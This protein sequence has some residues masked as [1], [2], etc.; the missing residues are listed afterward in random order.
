[1]P[2]EFDKTPNS[3]EKLKKR[4]VRVRMLMTK[5]EY[6]VGKVYEVTQ[7]LA[8]VWLNRRHAE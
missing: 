8:R 5:G 3:I 4:K 6:E 2:I 1:M 7:D